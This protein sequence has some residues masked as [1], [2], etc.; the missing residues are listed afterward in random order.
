MDV[1]KFKSAV[2]QRAYQYLRR[3][4]QD[5]SLDV[6]S[7]TSKSIEG[8]PVECLHV[9]LR[10]QF[11]KFYSF[12]LTFCRHCEVKDPS[13]SELSYFAQF[14]NVQLRSCERSVFCKPNLAGDE[15]SGLKTFVVKLMIIMSKVRWIQLT[16]ICCLLHR[17]LQLPL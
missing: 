1:K 7:Y 12:F 6:F 13:W 3:H 11:F 17:T 10:W 8:S 15:L 5:M 4:D 14:L 2:F 16:K 9:L